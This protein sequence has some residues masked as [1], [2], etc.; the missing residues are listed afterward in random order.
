MFKKIILSTIVAV[1]AMS[2]SSLSMAVVPG[3]HDFDEGEPASS[4]LIAELEELVALGINV[5][6][7]FDDID[8]VH[9]IDAL[10]N[11]VE[12]GEIDEMIARELLASLR[13]I[14]SITIQVDI[15]LSAS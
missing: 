8:V 11:A 4:I 1:M 14:S 7:R 6:C 13:A 12:S 2:M 3:N 15:D 5:S 10:R 9:I